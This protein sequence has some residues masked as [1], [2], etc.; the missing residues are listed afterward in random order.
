MIS[1]LNPVIRGW[2]NYYATV[3]SK[4][5]FR[6]EDRHVFVKL[7]QWVQRRHRNKSADWI[8]KKY[9]RLETG[10]WDFA[11]PNGITLYRHAQTPIRRHVK[12]REEKSLYDGDWRYWSVRLGRHPELSK[13]IA[14]LLK[15]QR[16]RCAWCGLHFKPEDVWEI[17]HVIPTSCGGTDAWENRQLLHGHCHDQ[18]TPGDGS[19]ACRCP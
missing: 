13:R 14:F 6:E 4:E 17:D 19:L 9:W 2:A 11:T 18:K 15:R 5:V 16:G 12:V 3:A 7:W 8:V 10:S 1:R